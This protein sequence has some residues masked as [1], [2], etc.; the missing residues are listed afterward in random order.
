MVNSSDQLKAA[1]LT[2]KCSG[3]LSILGSSLIL[4][5]ILWRRRQCRGHSMH[6]HDDVHRH[7]HNGSSRHQL[8]PR[9]VLL[10]ILVGMSFF[11]VGASSMYIVGSWAIDP[12]KAKANVFAPHGTEGTCIA[13]GALFQTFASALPFY[14]LSLAIYYFLTVKRNWKNDKLQRNAWAFHA[15]PIFFG[16]STAVYGVAADQFHPNELWCWFSGTSQS[17]K[18]K[19]M[20]YYGPLWIIFIVVVTLFVLIYRHVRH[21]EK[22]NF[23]YRFELSIRA[24]SLQ[25]LYAA[26]LEGEHNDDDDED[27][28]DDESGAMSASGPG[29]SRSFFAAAGS[30]SSRLASRRMIFVRQRQLRKQLQEAADSARLSRPVFWQGVLFSC[31]FVL[32]FLFPTVVR[33]YQLFEDTAPFPLLYC[34]TLLLPLQGFMN[35]LVYFKRSIL[36]FLNER[37]LLARKNEQRS[38]SGMITSSNRPTS[39]GVPPSTRMLRVTG[40]SSSS[41]R[42]PSLSSLNHADGTAGDAATGS[43]HMVIVPEESSLAGTATKTSTLTA[44]ADNGLSSNRYAAENS[45]GGA[46][47]ELSVVVEEDSKYASSSYISSRDISSSSSSF[48][49]HSLPQSPGTVYGN[50]HHQSNPLL[51]ASGCAGLPNKLAVQPEE[52][53]EQT[54]ALTT[55]QRLSVQPDDKPEAPTSEALSVPLEEEGEDQELSTTMNMSIQ[56]VLEEGDEEVPSDKALPGQ[57]TGENEDQEMPTA[58]TLS[59]QPSETVYVPEQPNPAGERKQPVDST[60]AKD[61]QHQPEQETGT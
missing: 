33:T 43:S 12:D 56:P 15:G 34:M 32:T 29:S 26:S 2:A 38:Q 58:N 8:P 3:A 23:R 42:A 39:S 46:L 31:A 60:T 20:L 24:S 49:P 47:T 44:M 41:L 28:H 5:D 59:D 61:E 54:E 14:N 40:A 16:I 1:S 51:N 21:Q 7:C 4:W 27:D 18:L 6:P 22:A 13:Q 52:G 35:C 57:H 17:N 19:F 37:G 11:D 45:S 10:H 9:T 55:I 50:K 36:A 53:D 30:L 48:L 25:G